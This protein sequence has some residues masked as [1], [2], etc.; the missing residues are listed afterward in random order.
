MREVFQNSLF[1]YSK[2]SVCAYVA[3][4]NEEFSKRLLEKDMEHRQTVQE[5]KEQLERLERENEQLRMARQEVAGAL[6]DAKTFAAGLMEQAEA[7]SSALRSHNQ[8]YHRAECQRLQALAATIDA[9]REDFRSALD[10][11]DRD[12]EQYKVKCQ[13]I[14]AQQETPPADPEEEESPVAG[15]EG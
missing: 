1:G 15:N 4:M 10:R 13:A 12:M 7:E 3:E 2:K 11:M 9:L 8:A 14:Q 5:L 6:I